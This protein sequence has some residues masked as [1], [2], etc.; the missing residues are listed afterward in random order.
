[1]VQQL[2]WPGKAQRVADLP[3][4]AEEHQRRGD[5]A[6]ALW[7]RLVAGISDKE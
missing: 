5:A 6:D 3:M 4:T 1:V 7:R 2:A